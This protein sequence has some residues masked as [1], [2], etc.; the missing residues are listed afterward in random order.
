MMEK[1]KQRL[2]K[3][4][5]ERKYLITIEFLLH[6]SE[7]LNPNIRLTY[8]MIIIVQMRSNLTNSK[9]TP[10]TV[11]RTQRMR[12]FL[13]RQRKGFLKLQ[14]KKI[15][16]KEGIAGKQTK[17]LTDNMCIAYQAVLSVNF[18]MYMLTFI[19]NYFCCY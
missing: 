11:M 18:Y 3:R 5:M 4:R 10:L 17:N 13:I 1:I 6:L 12:L 14:S 15:E 19:I 9:M 7:N 2:R 8:Q 16:I